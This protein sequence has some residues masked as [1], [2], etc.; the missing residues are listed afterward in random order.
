MMTSLREGLSQPDAFPTPLHSSYPE[1]RHRGQVHFWGAGYYLVSR[2][3]ACENKVFQQGIVAQSCS[4]SKEAYSSSSRAGLRRYGIPADGCNSPPPFIPI[5]PCAH[6][7]TH[8][9]LL[10]HS[11]TRVRRKANHA[12]HAL[13][14]GREAPRQRTGQL[15]RADETHTHGERISAIADPERREN[16]GLGFY[17][18]KNPDP[19]SSEHLASWYALGALQGRPRQDESIRCQIHRPRLGH[20]SQPTNPR[21]AARGRPIGGAFRRAPASCSLC[22]WNLWLRPS[23]PEV[24]R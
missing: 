24:P 16:P 1:R 8:S 5:G 6:S 7:L 9:P 10:T 20:V 15:A 17:V 11:F 18:Y 2:Q 21:L 23:P 4:P 19:K 3:D 13:T 22:G 14:C 12:D